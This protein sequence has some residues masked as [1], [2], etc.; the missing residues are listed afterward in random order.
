MLYL[1]FLI[2]QI[3]MARQDP[4]LPLIPRYSSCFFT[5][6][7]LLSLFSETYS[8]LSDQGSWCV[9]ITCSCVLWSKDIEVIK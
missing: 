3:P 2:A 4:Q 5:L 6:D 9:Y 8:F 1:R 7:S